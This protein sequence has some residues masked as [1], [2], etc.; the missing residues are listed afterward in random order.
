MASNSNKSDNASF[1][2]SF[3][4]CTATKG[5]ISCESSHFLYYE[6]L[7]ADLDG[8]NDGNSPLAIRRVQDR[9]LRKHTKT[10]RV[11]IE[12]N[13]LYTDVSSI[14]KQNQ[15][16]G[17]RRVRFSK[18]LCRDMTGDA[19]LNDSPSCSR[20]ATA[21][22]KLS[23]NLPCDDAGDFNTS[24]STTAAMSMS[25]CSGS[26]QS[27]PVA[28]AMCD[29]DDI[30]TLFVQDNAS[31]CTLT[32]I[33]E[34]DEAAAS[35]SAADSRRTMESKEACKDVIGLEILV[36]QQ[37]AK[38][39]ASS[40]GPHF[41]TFDK[42]RK[43][44]KD[45]TYMPSSVS[46]VLDETKRV[47]TFRKDKKNDQATASPR[48][49]P[50]A[51]K[52]TKL[53]STSTDI[54]TIK[55][56]AKNSKSRSLMSS[57]HGSFVGVINLDELSVAGSPA[58]S[59]LT[60]GLWNAAPIM[61]TMGGTSLNGRSMIVSTDTCMMTPPMMPASYG[62]PHHRQQQM[63]GT[64]IGDVCYNVIPPNAQNYPGPVV[65]NSF[66]LDLDFSG[67]DPKRPSSAAS[68]TRRPDNSTDGGIGSNNNVINKKK[69]SAQSPS[70]SS[71]G[72]CLK[73]SSS[74]SSSKSSPGEPSSS[75]SPARKKAKT[76]TWKKPEGKPK[77]P[78]S[79]YNL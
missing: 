20:T 54:I 22:K 75:S 15:L 62:I 58:V 35:H 39:L 63:P 59:L 56:K 24:C 73:N 25:E 74:S 13:R 43:S 61:M 51:A 9:L 36:K 29:V 46:H 65:E 19:A 67:S 64:T 6:E 44:S 14:T 71:G 11:R 23:S 27:Y 48:A 38:Q 33:Q 66:R 26:I 70:A 32:C 69:R 60:T 5:A 17:H 52:T 40:S 76:W 41:N 45:Y 30:S 21:V 28:V 2:H 79:A 53:S 37:A 16:A 72:S 55:S 50:P 1:A 57:K 10:G 49:A 4:T 7:M 18:P 77:R 31:T 34:A 42:A 3:K 68:T 8:R 78:L 47:T 12:K